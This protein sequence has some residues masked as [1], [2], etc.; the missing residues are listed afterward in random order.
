MNAGEE[1]LPSFE[2]FVYSKSLFHVK[3]YD[4]LCEM[5]TY[6]QVKLGQVIIS[7]SYKY[8]RTYGEP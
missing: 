8:F 6:N 7:G 4:K 1:L 3:M 2:N 5:W